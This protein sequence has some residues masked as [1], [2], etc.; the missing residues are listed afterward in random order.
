[1][2]DEVVMKRGA[3]YYLKTEDYQKMKHRL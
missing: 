1:M 2:M 3:V